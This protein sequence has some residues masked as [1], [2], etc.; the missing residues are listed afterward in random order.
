M[1]SLTTNVLKILPTV[2]DK[3]V[4]KNAVRIQVNPTS[5]SKNYNV[6]AALKITDTT[7]TKRSV[8][9]LS[10]DIQT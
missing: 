8:S 6:K 1:I 7:K 9:L 2:M 10:H 5:T 3:T 4:S